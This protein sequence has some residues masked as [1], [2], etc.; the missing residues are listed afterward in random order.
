MIDSY[1]VPD[2]NGTRESREHGWRIG[3][4]LQSADG[5]TPSE[6]AY[7]VADRQINGQITYN[8]AAEELNEYHAEHPDQHAHYE[9]DIVAQRISEILQNPGFAFAPD[10]LKSIHKRLFTDVLQDATGAIRNDWVGDWRVENLTKKEPVLHGDTV[11]YSNFLWIDETIN[12][13]FDKEKD[14]IGSY[15]RADRHEVADSVFRFLSGI[16]Q[17]HPFREGNTRTTAVFGIIYLN[18]LGFKI[19]NKPFADNSQYFRDALVLANT[20]DPE[21]QTEEPLQRFVQAALFDHTIQLHSLR[22]KPATPSDPADPTNI[23][24][25][26]LERGQAYGR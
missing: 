17:I 4:G 24:M 25:E 18:F 12:Y 9:A 15:R 8:Q 11:Q 16:W 2:P 10:V 23:A 5:L 19:D 14:R 22:E 20:S 1:E 13:D 6:Y 7:E 26:S 21:L 3:F